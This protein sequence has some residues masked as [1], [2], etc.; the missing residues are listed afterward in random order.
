MIWHPNETAPRTDEEDQPAVLILRDG[1][2][3][4]AYWDPEAGYFQG[5]HAIDG[6]LPGNEMPGR[7]YG[8]THWSPLPGTSG[9]PGIDDMIVLLGREVLSTQDL[10]DLANVLEWLALDRN[11]RLEDEQECNV[12][13]AALTG[14]KML[15]DAAQSLEQGSR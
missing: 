8:A 1:R 10:R 15:R 2:R 14:A 4:V 5:D 13:E 12:V 3:Y 9:P 6:E 7:L 11:G